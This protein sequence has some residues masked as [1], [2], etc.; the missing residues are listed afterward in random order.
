MLYFKN[1][2]FN[3]NGVN[4]VSSLQNRDIFFFRR[5]PWKIYSLK[6]NSNSLIKGSYTL[7]ERLTLYL[8]DIGR[9]CDPDGARTS[10][11]YIVPRCQIFLTICSDYKGSPQTPLE[12]R[13]CWRYIHL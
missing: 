3:I 6:R 11:L 8:T 4:G 12:R 5:L 9:H 13:H 2:K 7:S 1:T 10:L